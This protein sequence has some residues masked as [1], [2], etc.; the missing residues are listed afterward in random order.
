MRE[1]MDA[2]TMQPAIAFQSRY[3]LINNPYS[4]NAA[5]TNGFYRKSKIVM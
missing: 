2:A 4:G 3:G 5:G 1:A